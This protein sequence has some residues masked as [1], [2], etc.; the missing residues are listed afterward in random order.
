M[1]DEWI[2]S[3]ATRM[4]AALRTGELSSEELVAACLRRIAEVNP[5]IN[6]VVQLADASALARARELDA[7]NARGISVGPLHGLPFSVKDIFD[8]QGIISS[9]GLEERAD[10]IPQQDAVVVKR[11]K[12][13][14]AILLGKT[15]CP[16]EGAGGESVNLVYGATRNPYNLDCSPG[17]SSGGEAAILAAG[18]SPLGLGSDSGGSIR[19]PAHYCGIA[20]LRPTSGRVP[21]TGAYGLPG[22]LSDPRSQ[23][24]P[25]ARYVEDLALLLPIISGEDWSDSSVIPMPWRDPA[26]VS[27]PALRVAFFTYDEVVT[28]TPET[29]ETV[30]RAV[31]ALQKTGLLVEQHCPPGIAEAFA[32]TVNYW[33]HNEMSGLEI[34]E[35]KAR[36]DGFR[37]R[38]L[39]FMQNW[40]L[41]L[42]PASATPAVLFGEGTVQQFS[43]TLPYSLTG[44]PSLV[45]R[46]GTSPEGL[47][48]AVQV[49]G[50]PWRE[51]VVLAVAS[52]LETSLGG[53]Q[54]P[55]M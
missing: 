29:V 5:R 32:I 21:A 22:G 34:E 3:S 7:L 13:A 25:M 6:A 26:E 42:C 31:D 11:L 55:S 16:P 17:G 30:E 43:Y 8:T 2:F 50:R 49:V 10:F 54:C 1:M 37:S 24:G 48:I 38:M 12:D 46:A 44:Y 40:D 45:V 28:S 39:A 14:G 27:L 18:G 51:D 9:A 41:I 47:P 19:L 4:L 33:R 20:G 52:A 15:N 23:I 53:W 36:W 35:L